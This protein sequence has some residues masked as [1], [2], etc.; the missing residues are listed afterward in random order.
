M[1]R[2]ALV[3]VAAAAVAADWPEWRGQGRRGVWTED[4]I[5]DKLPAQ[6]RP[7]WRAPV[8]AGYSGPAVAGGRVFVTDY[9]E[10]RER[11]LSF[12]ESTGRL[13]WSRDWEADYRGIDYASGP[14]ATPTIDAGLVFVQGAAGALRCYDAWEGEL[15]WSHDYRREFDTQVPAWGMSAAP[16][17]HKGMVIAVVGGRRDAK[18]VAFH[19]RTGTEIWRALSSSDSEPGYSQ[20]MLARVGDSEQ[21]IVWHAGAVDSLDPATGRRLWDHP[22]KIHMSTPI[23]TPVQ[24]GPYLLVS[25]FFQGS[26]MFKL[27]ESAPRAELLWRG[28]S[29]SERN[30]DTLHALMGSPIIAGGYVYGVCNYGELRCLRASDG[31][32]VWETQSATVEKARNVSAFLVRQFSRTVI[33][34]DRGELIFARLSPEGYEE[35][36]RTKLIEPTSKPGARRELNAVAWA[37][38]AFANRHVVAR[39][40]RE[41][42]RVSL[43]K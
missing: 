6:L 42:V 29:E 4:G 21:L 14:R 11:L 35:L 15:R 34:N 27:D 16:L 3:S 1:P 8:G 41:V 36:S 9:A 40:D 19:R 37:H 33:F 26:R 25:A 17:A 7:V 38:P 2:L 12:E 13:V 39:N 5:I 22:F 32:R 10:G 23:A 24:S 20:P 30:T 31:K 43:A 18:V 28:M